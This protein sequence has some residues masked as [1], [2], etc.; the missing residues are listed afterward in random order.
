M[1]NILATENGVF[2]IHKGFKKINVKM[3]LIEDE[4]ER[5]KHLKYFCENCRTARGI[6][7]YD[8]KKDQHLLGTEAFKNILNF[9]EFIQLVEV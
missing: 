2:K 5:Y 7:G 6:F 3:E 1:K 8:R 9:I 4:E